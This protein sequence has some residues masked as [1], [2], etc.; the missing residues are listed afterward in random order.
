MAKTVSLQELADA[1]I[2][3]RKSAKQGATAKA[4]PTVDTFLMVLTSKLTQYDAAQ[5]ARETK[6]GGRGNIYRM[7]LLFEAQD[8]VK[9]D[10][11]KVLERS[12]PEAMAE[13]KKSLGRR[14]ETDFPPVRN[15]QRQIDSWV[16]DGRHPS[17]VRK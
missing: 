5:F 12:D 10:C 9:A 17:I 2:Q 16:K 14:F 7:G 15:V 1:E 3:L 6:R 13:L 11:A 8:K 4:L